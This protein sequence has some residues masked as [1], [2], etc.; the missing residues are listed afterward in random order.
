MP[1]PRIVH[2]RVGVS[3]RSQLGFSTERL[4]PPLKD[5]LGSGGQVLL[6]SLGAACQQPSTDRSFWEF[7]DMLEGPLTELAASGE[8]NLSHQTR[9]GKPCENSRKTI[10]WSP[11]TWLGEL[12]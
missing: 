6:M 3:H 9:F 5:S 4:V 2:Q 12:G 11:S 7:Y 10:T 8:S 1:A